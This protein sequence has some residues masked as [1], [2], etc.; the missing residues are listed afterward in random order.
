MP[1]SATSVFRALLA[2]LCLAALAAPALAYTIFLKD[3]T[4]VV[5]KGKYEVK[6]NQ[7]IIVLPSGTRSSLPLADIDVERTEKANVQDLGT[8]V[9]IEGG[10]VQD[11]AQA[12]GTPRK[13]NLQDLIRKQQ[14]G[15]REQPPQ[16]TTRPPIDDTRR[17]RPD[18]SGRAPF[19]DTNLANAIQAH[20]ITLGA[21]GDV[22]QG[23]SAS[24]ARIL[25]ETRS[26]GAVFKSLLGAANTLLRIREQYPGRVDAFEIRCEV[27]EDGSPAGRFTL[28]PEVAAELVSGRLELTRFFVENVEF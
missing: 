27:P 22:Y 5:A 28:T 15:V 26:E 21:A 8:A 23:S 7:A 3:G 20:L 6:G 9:M 19:R 18:A 25:F 1:K 17:I 4:Q 24:R 12:T 13:D 11:V 16:K 10:R 2:G 14:A